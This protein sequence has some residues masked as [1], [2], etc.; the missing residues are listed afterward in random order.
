[1]SANDDHIPVILDPAQEDHLFPTPLTQGINQDTP[2]L[3]IP[4]DLFQLLHQFF[5]LL[6][7]DITFKYT[8]LHV[9]PVVFQFLEHLVSSLCIADIVADYIHVSSVCFQE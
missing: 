2:I 6:L 3:L 1:M 9:L 8:E 7:R 4:H 5:Q